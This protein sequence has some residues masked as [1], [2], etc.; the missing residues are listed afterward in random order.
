MSPP[1][2]TYVATNIFAI[3]LLQLLHK[4]TS[5]FINFLFIIWHILPQHAS[6]STSTARHSCARPAASSL[7]YNWTICQ[8]TERARPLC[9]CVPFQPSEMGDTHVHFIRPVTPTPRHGPSKLKTFTQ[10]CSSRSTGE[11]SVTWMDRHITWLAWLW[12]TRHQ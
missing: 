9:Q 8:L 11:K 1:Y 10:K 6:D 5:R 4:D 2:L 3:Y 7:S 12:P